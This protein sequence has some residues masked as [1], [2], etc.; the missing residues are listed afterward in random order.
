[1]TKARAYGLK[2]NVVAEHCKYEI[3]T[4]C[5][6]F[7]RK[8]GRLR[9]KTAKEI[10]EVVKSLMPEEDLL[11]VSCLM[12]ETLMRYGCTNAEIAKATGINGAT[13]SRVRSGIRK[14]SIGDAR[15]LYELYQECITDEYGVLKPDTPEVR[16]FVELV[17]AGKD[18][19]KLNVPECSLKLYGTGEYPIPRDILRLARVEVDKDLLSEKEEKEFFNKLNMFVKRGGKLAQVSLEVG[20]SKQF[21][22]DIQNKKVKVT[23]ELGRRLNAI[24]ANQ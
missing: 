21:L 6:Y 9:T 14:P 5:K 11:S 20:E 7:G 15:K 2:A 4:V 18:L 19:R 3:A 16:Q 24:F 12:V 1:M 10:Y 8:K 22:S 17:R 13:L 23:K